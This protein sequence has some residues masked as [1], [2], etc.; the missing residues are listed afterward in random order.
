[1]RVRFLGSGDAFGSGGRF[2]TCIMLD[3]EEGGYLVDCGATSLVA[4]RRFGVDPNRIRAVFIS[5]LHGDHFGGLPFLILD[6]QLVSRRVAPLT[7]AGP[8]GLGNRIKAALEVFFPGSSKVNRQFPVEVI[9]LT[10]GA[11]ALVAGIAVTP[12]EVRH[13]SGATPFAL[14]LELGGR[15]VTYTGDTEWTDALIPAARGADLLIAE[16]YFFEKPVKFHLSYADI[17]DRVGELAAKRI[18][19]T[20]ASADML[21]RS[22]EVRHEMAEDGKAVEI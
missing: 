18:I 8:P 12:Y 7:V 9:E 17:R 16:A 19:L 20:H 2:N 5:H 13:P 1:M 21:A 10:P 6:G 22:D 3:S 4:M 14:R 15:I 11:R